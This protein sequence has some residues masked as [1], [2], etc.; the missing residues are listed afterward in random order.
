MICRTVSTL[1]LIS[2]FATPIAAETRSHGAHVHGVGTLDI[3]FEGGDIQMELEAP[4]ADIVGFEY[5]ATDPEDRKAIDAAIAMLARPLA[6]FEVSD[7]A[8]CQ[9]EQAQVSHASLEGDGHAHDDDHSNEDDHAHE[10]KHDHDDHAHEVKAGHAAFRATYRLVC[11]DVAAIDTIEFRYFE[12]F[13]GAEKL[14]VQLV[15]ERTASA[16]DVTRDAP[17]LDLRGRI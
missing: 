11:A 3:A 10:D 4:G 9:V 13:E 14:Q 7:A 2:V 17:M 1:A 6:L 16:H 12:Q 15:S 8:G 5:E